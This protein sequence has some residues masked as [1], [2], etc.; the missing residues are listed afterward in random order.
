MPSLCTGNF[1]L[2]KSCSHHTLLLFVGVCETWLTDP[3]SPF[4]PNYTSYRKDRETGEVG[5]SLLLL[6][7]QSL[8]SSPLSITSFSGGGLEH[9]GVTVDFD[10]G[11]LNILLI[12][13]P[14]LNISLQEFQHLFSQIPI[15]TS[16]NWPFPGAGETIQVRHL[17]FLADS[18][19]LS[20]LTPPGL[21]TRIDPVSGNPST[22]DLCLGNGPL[23]LTTITIGPYMG[24]D[25]LPVIIAF[26]SVPLTSP[27]SCRPRCS[28]KKGDLV[29]FQT[30]IN[31]IVPPTTLPS[32]DKIHFL[33][34]VLVTVESHHFHL[35]TSSPSCFFRVPWWSQ[36]CVAALQAKQ[37]AF[38]ARRRNPIPPL[39][40]RF[41]YLEAQ[42]KHVIL[43][44]KWASFCASLSFSNSVC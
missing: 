38:T 20:L 9:L 2:L 15:T 34:E 18:D 29:F 43:D 24:S 37:H 1:Q 27:T 16:G 5:G 12:Y 31:S 26:P 4:F 41:H 22:L 33:I 39:C 23:L 13:N 8:P 25:H 35:V 30:E 21:P 11:L 28:L 10:M 7:H 32:V 44:E 40:Q 14:C 19:S 42:C 6:I 36:K 17:S 3:F